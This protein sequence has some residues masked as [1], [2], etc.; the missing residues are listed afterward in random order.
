MAGGKAERLADHLRLLRDGVAREIGNVE[1]DGGPEANHAGDGGNEEGKE[2]GIGFE[3]TGSA[4]NGTETAGFAGDPPKQQQADGEHE[5]RGDAFQ[6]FDG[7]DAAHDDEHVR[8]PRRRRSRPICRLRSEP[9]W[10]DTICSMELMAEPPIQVWMPNQP[11]A[12]RARKTAG[13]FAPRTPKE[14]RTKTGNG[15][16]YFAPAW[17]LSSMGIENDQVA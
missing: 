9:N 6:N 2:F 8:A 4:E 1:R 11:Q 16:P 3:F 13:T 12:T 7:F 15:M 17:A 5:G 14:A 10:R